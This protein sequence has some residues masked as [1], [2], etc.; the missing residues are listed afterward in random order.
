MQIKFSVPGNPKA[1]KRPKFVRRGKY[2]GAYDPS[3]KDKD[4]FLSIALASKPDKPLEVPLFIASC[5]YFPRPKSHYNKKGL[6]PDAPFYHTSRPDIDNLEKM[7]YDA[8]NGI[9]FKDDSLICRTACHKLY[10]DVP[11]TEVTIEY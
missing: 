11:R 10:G 1:L 7:I 5:F 3:T 6:K 2:V 8:L 9:F 4:T